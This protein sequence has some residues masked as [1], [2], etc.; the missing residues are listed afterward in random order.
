[1]VHQFEFS[2]RIAPQQ[3]RFLET[4]GAALDSIGW[5]Q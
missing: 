4:M 5:R 3:R 2:L 1:V